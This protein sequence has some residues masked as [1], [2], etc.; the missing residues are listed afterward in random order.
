MAHSCDDERRRED[1]T[2]EQSWRLF[3]LVVIAGVSY[4]VPIVT[5]ILFK[6]TEIA[7]ILEM[8]K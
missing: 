2:D 1:M 4:L 3:R 8:R 5:G 6:L 7:K